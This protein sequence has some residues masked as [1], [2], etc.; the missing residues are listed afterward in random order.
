MT[1]SPIGEIQV[2]HKHASDGI[3]F[4]HGILSSADTFKEMKAAFRQDRFFDNWSIGTFEYDFYHKME[5]NAM[6]LVQL[7]EH[8]FAERPNFRLTLICHSMGGLIARI[9]VIMGG[10]RLPFLKRIVMLG[11]PNF[12]ALRP[13]RMAILGQLFLAASG[14][15]WGI[16]TRQTGIRDLT[17]VETIMKEVYNK[18]K[19]ENAGS[20]EYVTMAGLYF[21]DNRYDFPSGPG[22]GTLWAELF[23]LALRLLP[24]LGINL[25]RP[26]DGIVELNSVKMN[27]EDRKSEKHHYIFAQ[28][29]IPRSYTHVTHFKENEELT[30][31]M[32]NNN[33]I[34]I[35]F[36]IAL[37]KEGSVDSWWNSALTQRADWMI[38]PN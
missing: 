15:L 18:G 5:D 22:A 6:A 8:E 25:E 37:S 21:H 33:P 19:K 11:T 2:V 1:G 9:A 30:H 35:D 16:Y 13:G 14:K 23:Q 20:V 4:I 34:L 7:L 26:H 12:G 36:L 24:A 28:K 3:I 17:R 32:L 38:S 27:N 29:N 31:T 10:A